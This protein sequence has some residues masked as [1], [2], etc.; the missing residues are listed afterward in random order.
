MAVANFRF[1]MVVFVMA[2]FFGN[3]FFQVMKRME[4]LQ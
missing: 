4:G 3:K 2:M 1:V